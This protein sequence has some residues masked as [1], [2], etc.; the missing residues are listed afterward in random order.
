MANTLELV[1]GL[2]L[3]GVG[4]YLFVTKL[5]PMIEEGF[6][7]PPSRAREMEEEERIPLQIIEDRYPD[8]VYED[9][10]PDYYVEDRY[11]DYYPY[12][13]PVYYPSPTY[14][15][16][17]LC[18]P[19][20]YWNGERCKTIHNNIDCPSGYREHDGQC[21]PKHCDDDEYFDGRD[22]RKIII[23][24]YHHRDDDNNRRGDKKRRLNVR[25]NKD[26]D[27][28]D[29]ERRGP[30]SN[31]RDRWHKDRDVEES[32]KASINPEK[33]EAEKIKESERVTEIAEKAVQSF[34]EVDFL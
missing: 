16:P 29:R 22:C 7:A 25:K 10:Y 34:I 21:R 15:Y 31:S 28:T 8:I 2:G 3:V 14:Y 1:L 13:Y 17:T 11:P 33:V 18:P 9:R 12:A 26:W 30:P 32:I 19:G 4:G 5:W 6:E 20:K 23:P 24:S 27:R